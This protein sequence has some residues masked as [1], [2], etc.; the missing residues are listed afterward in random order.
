VDQILNM[1]DK[2]MELLKTV[3]SK[4]PEDQTNEQR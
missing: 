4:P 2:K 1:N 3:T